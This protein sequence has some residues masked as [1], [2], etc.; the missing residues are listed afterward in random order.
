[1]GWSERG[2]EKVAMIRV[3]TKNGGV[4]ESSDIG[5]DKVKKGEKRKAMTLSKKYQ[6]LVDT[7]LNNV[8]R[9]SKDFSIFEADTYSTGKIDG[10]TAALKG[11][12]RRRRVIYMLPHERFFDS[13]R[14]T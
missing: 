4:I 1:M 12:G 11:L 3:Y 10:T 7:Q 6:T 9:S 5:K 14:K 13:P 8:I 2:L